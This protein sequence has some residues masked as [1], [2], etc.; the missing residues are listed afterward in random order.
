MVT[1][2]TL[3]QYRLKSLLGGIAI[4]AI[5]VAFLSMAAR[6]ELAIRQLVLDAG[7]IANTRSARLGL[8]QI[9]WGIDLSG[10]RDAKSALVAA[11]AKSHHIKRLILK[12]TNV[13][14]ETM[15]Y[16]GQLRELEVLDLSGTN[17]G[18][19]GLRRIRQLVNLEVLLLRDLGVSDKVIAATLL[20]NPRLIN[21]DLTST[22][23]GE[24]TLRAVRRLNQ[25][26]LCILSGTGITDETLALIDGHETISGLVL[27]GCDISDTGIRN[28]QHMP[29]LRTISLLE[30]HVTQ[31]GED[32]LF[33]EFPSLCSICTRYGKERLRSSSCSEKRRE[34]EAD[35]MEGSPTRNKTQGTRHTLRGR[36]LGKLG[37]SQAPA[38]K[39][40]PDRRRD[41][42][43]C[44][45]SVRCRRGGTF[46]VLWGRASDRHCDR[47]LPT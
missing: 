40:R 39:L 7:G 13:N 46:P 8:V 45:P 44:Q 32:Y 35:Q 5:V 25:L 1:Q 47:T 9:V 14:D 37:G 26:D 29:S 30:T 17:V 20:R 2:I 19:L 4:L 28:L 31:D 11:I 15:G 3:F 10:C 43:C 34:D 12:N 38:R 42:R 33:G 23:A 41:R 22:G 21:L 18:D 24:L 16:I 6:R 27:R 36:R